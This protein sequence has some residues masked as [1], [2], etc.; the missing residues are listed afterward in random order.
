R[1]AYPSPLW[2]RAAARQGSSTTRPSSPW[3]LTAL[4]TSPTRAIS[5]S[6]NSAL[7][8]PQPQL[9]NKQRK[10]RHG[11]SGFAAPMLVRPLLPS[12]ALSSWSVSRKL[13]H[14]ERQRRISSES[15]VRDFLRDSSFHSE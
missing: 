2:A 11:S 4:S 13:C 8:P 5:G 12:S 9:H 1:M 6:R 3:P 7:C 15:Y 10:L 14:S